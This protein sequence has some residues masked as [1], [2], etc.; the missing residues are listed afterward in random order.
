MSTVAVGAFL[1]CK[2]QDLMPYSFQ[3]KTE[4]DRRESTRFAGQRA[5]PAEL[6]SRIRRISQEANEAE[7]AG[8]TTL[9][10]ILQDCLNTGTPTPNEIKERKAELR[11]LWPAK[12]ADG[13]PIE[14]KKDDEDDY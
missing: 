6:A 14:T 11:A 12:M 9:R 10:S 4:R 8:D 1:C 3:L 5:C 13:P 2:K 7:Q